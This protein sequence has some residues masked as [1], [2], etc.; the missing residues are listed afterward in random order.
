MAEDDI[1][2]NAFS[3]MDMNPSSFADAGQTIAIIV[4][5]FIGAVVLFFLFY[6]WWNMK[7]YKHT[8][9]LKNKTS[10]VPIIKVCKARIMYEKSGIE[11]SWKLLKPKVELPVPPDYAREQTE[12][13]T[14][15]VEAFV[16]AEKGILYVVAKSKKNTVK[17]KDEDLTYQEIGG[18]NTQSTSEKFSTNNKIFYA[19]QLERA[20]SEKAKIGGWEVL[21]KAIMPLFFIMVLLLLLLFIPGVLE[22]WN[23]NMIQPTGEIM[24]MGREY[25]QEVKAFGDSV[26]GQATSVRPDTRPD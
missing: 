1:L 18:E 25:M 15:Y 10:G 20:K 19:N 9:V 13:G 8:V 3:S 22:S 11:S 26:C 4:G 17:I 6:I 24:K 7:Q 16:H 21:N 2:T 23:D 5:V 12:K 14:N